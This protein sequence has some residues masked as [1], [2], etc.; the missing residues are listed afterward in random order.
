[1]KRVWGALICLCV[2]VPAFAHAQEGQAILGKPT[3]RG[4]LDKEII[5]GVIRKHRNEARYCYERQL[6]KDPDLSGK[7]SVEFVIS[8]G[9]RVA[10]AVVADTTLKNDAV[11][12]CVIGK[13]KRWSFPKP[14]DG[15][16]VVT[17]PFT[18][19][20][21]K[22]AATKGKPGAQQDAALGTLSADESASAMSGL[23][24][25]GLSGT[26]RTNAQVD[27]STVAPRVVPGKPRVKGSLDKEIIRRVVRQHRREVR[28]CYEK[29]L[30]KNPDLSGKI[31]VN[32]M[33]GST[34]AVKSAVVK[35]ST[36]ASDEVGSC[37]AK[38]VRR[39][40]FPEPKGGGVVVV[41]YPFVFSTK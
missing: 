23:G 22:T 37:V 19:S 35:G 4:S 16:V 32:F 15:A 39:W 29:Q 36:M 27:G 6:A 24:G 7:V 40:K 10:S 34:G 41:T 18:F 38:K 13:V 30:V 14:R 3:V 25:L 17:Y 28:Y 11:E 31:S 2:G 12:S 33:I 26:G 20:A 9:G 8:I 21:S 5:R 1:M